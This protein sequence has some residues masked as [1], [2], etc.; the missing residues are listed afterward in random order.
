[1]EAQPDADALVKIGEVRLPSGYPQRSV[2]Y[3]TAIRVGWYLASRSDESKAIEILQR[4]DWCVNELRESVR[5]LAKPLFECDY[6]KGI[7]QHK[8]AMGWERIGH[9]EKAIESAEVAIQRLERELKNC[10]CNPKWRLKL[11]ELQL[12]MSDRLLEA[13]ELENA[14]KHLSSCIENVS[15]PLRND[16]T[17]ERLR[18]LVIQCLAKKAALSERMNKQQQAVR[19]YYNAA[20][21][22]RRFVV[23]DQS[24]Y[25]QSLFEARLWLLSRVVEILGHV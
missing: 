9:R 12:Q 19:E 25:Q 11:A 18:I 22:C 17:N 4:N 13:N 1:M 14:E 21:D 24:K 6:F 15:Q 7:N 23:A 8:L 16:L 20:Q 10:P 5:S 3:P 2:T